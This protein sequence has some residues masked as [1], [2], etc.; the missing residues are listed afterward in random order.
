MDFQLIRDFDKSII[1]ELE[2]FFYKNGIRL[3]DINRLFYRENER[4]FI[5]R[6]LQN[7]GEIAGLSLFHRV[8]S[9]DLFWEFENSSITQYIREKSA[10]RIM[11]ID[12]IYTSKKSN[13]ENIKQI[14][15]TETLA[16]GVLK[17]Y[18]FAVFTG[19]EELLELQGFEKIPFVK[20]DLPIYMVNM[21][22]PCTLNLDVERAL[23]EPFLS[24]K[25]VKH[26]IERC[27]R[28]MQMAISKLYPGNLLLSFYRNIM[29][30]ALIKKICKENEVDTV[31]QVPRRLGKAMCVPFGDM[32]NRYIIPNTV[33]KTMHTEKIF[34]PDMRSYEIG[35]FP[36]Y[37]DLD[38]QVKMIK[39]FQRPVILVDD[40]L[41]K[42]YRI[43]A[44]DP[45]LKNENVNV[46]KIIVG[47]M[48]ARGKEIM[49]IQNRQVDCAYFV[50][51]LRLWF[52]EN[53]LYPF[54]GGNA[55]WRG[56]KPQRNLIPSINLILP[57]MSPQY[58]RDASK[59]AIYHLSKV[60]IE[61]ALDLFTIIER[62]YE[63][64]Y[65][66]NLTLSSLG[67]VFIAPRC[68]EAGNNM[69]YDLNIAPS[70]YIKNDLETL[71]K[72]ERSLN[73]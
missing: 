14:I 8:G 44:I 30:E 27:R 43:K 48:S 15:L 3:V 22:N 19:D 31:P 40:I 55:V 29:D 7:G 59:N 4:A 63:N 65:E 62:E 73:M 18:G 38:I 16:Y 41:S 12:G 61:N 57:Y 10:G 13:I 49:D 45:L 46:Q 66:R 6:D 11:L 5:V 36:Y 25:E 34:E 71:I 37:L 32:L 21:N 23:K 58:M 70:T 24:N 39:S 72:L 60:C 51:N 20:N 53:Q 52:N 42:G 17:D 26:S 54:V 33:T 56:A 64:I 50:P 2:R 1:E 67:R 9:I 68:P 69:Y 47:I 35:P 28:R